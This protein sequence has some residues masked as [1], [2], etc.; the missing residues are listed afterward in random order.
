MTAVPDATDCFSRI[1][2]HPEAAAY[3][4][5]HQIPLP[6]AL[7][8]RSTPHETDDFQLV[9]PAMLALQPLRLGKVHP[10][11]VDFVGGKAGH[12]R[13]FGGGRQQDLSKACGLH[14]QSSLSVLD[15]TAGL[16][17]DAFVLAT[18]GARVTMTERHPVLYALLADGWQR[19]CN[20]DQ[21]EVTEIAQRMALRSGDAR[22]LGLVDREWDVIYLDPMFPPR[23]KSA[24]VKADMQALHQLLGANT[25]PD[26]VDDT[27]LLQWAL[28]QSPRRVVV[29]RPC[30]ALPL[31]DRAPDHQWTG[32]ANR[33]DVYTLRRLTD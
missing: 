26:D 2:C 8:E 29:K 27:I 28:N 17:R 23:G 14:Q 5:V 9:A 24:K 30:H 22:H 31:T 19:A 15:A 7:P 21:P 10:V 1:C 6:K 18:L 25:E 32:K 33:Y 16:G 3:A 20:S 4:S 12:R 11:A 13:Q